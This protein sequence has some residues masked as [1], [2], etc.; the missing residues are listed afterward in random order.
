MFATVFIPEAVFMQ[1]E[2]V[3]SKAKIVEDILYCAS[4]AIIST[5][6]SQMIILFNKQ[7][8]DVFGYK[9]E[10]VI[11]KSLEILLPRGSRSGH[12]KHARKFAEEDNMRRRMT[13]RTEVRG[14]RKNGE[15][16]S[17]EVAISKFL[18]DGKYIFTAVLRDI[19]ERK[20]AELKMSQYASDLENRNRELAD[21][22]FV[23]SHDLQE[24]LRKVSLYADRVMARSESFDAF[25]KED[26]GKVMESVEKMRLRLDALVDFYRAISNDNPLE[27]VN[28]EKMVPV[29]LANMGL[30][31][32][33][34]EG[35]IRVLQLPSIESNKFQ[36][37]RLFGNLISNAVKFRKKNQPYSV[38]ISSRLLDD[39]F[40]EILVHDDGLGFDQKYA[41]LIFRPFEKLNSET[42][43]IGMGLTICHKVVNQLGGIIYI[44][45]AVDIGTT[46]II[47]LP[48]KQKSQM[49]TDSF[50]TQPFLPSGSSI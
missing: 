25:S 49:P 23:A 1:V 12:S 48:A 45:S 2:N 14:L 30:S 18:Q 13:D 40:W 5:D 22:A 43:G 11:G 28:L 24:P 42:P 39:G 34:S 26:L 29:V 4:D 10:E 19:T 36:M 46:A 6:E 44:K 33:C 50:I 20:E 38:T 17:A 8:E 9:A 15:E 37:H 16:F 35:K 32:D 47:K 27:T 41:D 31:P 21:F 3:E 7:A